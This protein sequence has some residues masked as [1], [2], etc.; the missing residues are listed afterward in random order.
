MKKFSFLLAIFT[1]SLG[2]YAQNMNEIKPPVAKKEPKVLKIHGYEITDNYAWLRSS[3]DKAGK[4][5]P[6]VEEYLVA[7]NNYTESVMGGTKDFQDAL[8]KE[9]LVENQTNRPFFAH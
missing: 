9:M 3:K 7:E 2:I 8:Y 6:E 5:R 1:L 4:V